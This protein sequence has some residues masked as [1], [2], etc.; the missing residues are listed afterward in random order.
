MRSKLHLYADDTQFYCTFKYQDRK[1]ISHYVN[2]DLQNY[3]NLSA[4]HCLLNNAEKTKVMLFGPQNKRDDVESD[5]RISISG[6]QI[7]IVDQ[8]RSLG[9]ILDS[10]LRFGPHITK[11]VQQTYAALKTVYASRSF[12]SLW[13][14]LLP[15]R[16]DR[17]VATWSQRCVPL[18][19]M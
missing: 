17:N 10:E 8:A 15:D 9:V 13:P 4:D 6:V 7:P 3:V 2:K 19:L 5:L 1:I 11:L 18:I 16:G 14:S 12:H